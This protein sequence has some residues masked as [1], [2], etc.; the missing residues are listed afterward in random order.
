M[1]RDT[2]R[3]DGQKDLGGEVAMETEEVSTGVSEEVGLSV[4]SLSVTLEPVGGT[5]GGARVTPN[6]SRTFWGISRVLG[7][8]GPK[9]RGSSS[10]VG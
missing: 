3:K 1:L 2:W 8:S 6:W 7:S 10:L 9:Q 5:L 4:V